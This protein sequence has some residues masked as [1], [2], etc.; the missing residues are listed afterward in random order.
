MKEKCNP[1]VLARLK[2]NKQAFTMGLI[3]ILLTVSIRVPAMVYGQDTKLNLSFKNASLIKIFSEIRKNS[4]YSFIYNVD[5]IKHIRILSL[6]VKDASIT[7]VL[8]H[9][10]KNTGFIYTIEDNVIVIRPITQQQKKYL[11]NGIVK[12]KKGEPIPGVTV[13]ISD[14]STGTATDAF[15][16]FTLESSEKVIKLTFSCIGYKK[17][18]TECTGN[19]SLTIVL[20]EEVADLDEVTVI[21]Y[22]ERSK[23][24]LISSISSVKG[25]D[26]EEIPASSLETLLQGRMS[27]VE[28]SNVAGSPGGGG[29]RVNIRGYNSLMITG[30]NDG[31]PLYVI[32]G[33]PVHSFTSPITGTNLMAELDPSTIESVEVLK[34]AASAAIYGSR[35]SNGVILITTKKGKSGRAKF[36]T[37]ISYSHSFLPETPLQIIGHGERKWHILAAKHLREGYYDYMTGE[38]GIPK[39]HDEAWGWDKG[40]YD[41]FWKNGQ[42][43][44]TE[45]VLHQLQDSLNP[46]YNNATNWWKYVFRTGKITNANLQASGGREN[47]KYM[48]GLGWFDEKGIML[49]SDF[50]RVNFISNLNI[51]PRKNF[52][53]DARVYMAYTDRSRG[54]RHTGF[55]GG[56]KVEGITVSPIDVSSLLPG[57]GSHVEE[58]LLKRLRGT[59]EKNV[60]FNIRGNL[61]LS[62]EIIKNLR[63]T[64]NLGMDYSQAQRNTFEPDYLSFE[65]LTTSTGEIQGNMMFQTEELINYNFQINNVHNFDFLGGFS[66]AR[67]TRNIFRGSGRGAPNNDVHYV[68]DNFPGII[69]LYGT[70]TAMQQYRSDFEEKILVSS[71]GRLTYN[72]K[73]K[74]LTE[75]SIRRDGSSVFG[76]DVR[77]ATFPAVAVGWAFSEEPF[78]KNLYWLG[79]AKLRASWGRSG[80][81]FED[82]Y[83]GHGRLK[84]GNLFMGKT[85]VSPEAMS[86]SHL[87]WE[88]SDQY[89][90]G[91]DADIYDYR[92]KIKADYYYKYTSSVLYLTPLPGNVY[93]HEKAWTNVMELSNE[94]IE[95]ETLFDIFRNTDIKWRMKLNVSRNWNRFEK[96]YTDMDIEGWII[97]RPI[98]GLYVYKDEGI[99]RSE[100]DIPVYFDQ[101][102]NKRILYFGNQS[103]PVSIG[104]RRIKDMNMDGK[105]DAEDLYYAGSALPILHGGLFHEVKWK[106]FDLN[107]LCAFSLGRKILNIFSKSSL[108]LTQRFSPLFYDYRGKTFWQEGNTQSDFPTLNAISKAYSGQFDGLTDSNIE[109]VNYMR[110]KQLTIG[111]NVNKKLLK[112]LNIEGIRV[113]FTGENLF[114]WSNYSGLDPELVDPV[115]GIDNGGHYPLARK[116]TLGLTVKF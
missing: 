34:D 83:L 76:K 116:L 67:W 21:A 64:A 114:L 85:G 74:Y 50:R 93:F 20:E 52:H 32:D 78:M 94:G 53:L 109:R 107:I 15:G 81:Q 25:K 100:K 31:S 10:L 99:I 61:T 66:Y 27:G 14:K 4:D 86:N 9:C 18:T 47:F 63:L 41:F 73:Q 3:C 7:E 8:E 23:R 57:K 2:T 84:I 24:D 36:S 29:S 13:Q 96:S 70:P 49:G 42:P 72:Y 90:I 48:V 71:F 45:W 12:D 75:L 58:E 111:Y 59:I 22:G 69:E 104:M 77:W 65:K 92:L 101:M 112:K 43:M 40:T 35:A 88:E 51:T 60:N 55:G 98:G 115:S 89:N 113:F 87:S 102:A 1:T 82:A 110:L 6:D 54:N 37:N 19:K 28:I 62:Y 33:V 68:D 11:Y 103:Y 38:N 56:A 95:I 5:D 79:F 108:S 16:K 44:E 39:S 30:I 91:V 105:I 17:I 106:D 97:G 80:Q 26:L 46:F